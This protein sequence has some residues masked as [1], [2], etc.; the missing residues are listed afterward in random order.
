MR[1]L[2]LRV[3]LGRVA[4]SK[5]EKPWE[6]ACREGWDGVSAKRRASKYLSEDNPV[7][8]D[9]CQAESILPAEEAPRDWVS[10]RR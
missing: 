10:R 3:P 9:R 1:T 8:A 4:E 2:P 6:I 7:K 5:D